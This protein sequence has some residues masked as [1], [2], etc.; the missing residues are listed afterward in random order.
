MDSH[1]DILTLWRFI[2]AIGIATIAVGWWRAY[3]SMQEK[4]RTDLARFFLIQGTMIV[5]HPWQA[6]ML[7]GT[8]IAFGPV[9]FLFGVLLNENYFDMIELHLHEL[10]RRHAQDFFTRERMSYRICCTEQGREYDAWL[11]ECEQTELDAADYFARVGACAS[12]MA[13]YATL[14]L[15]LLMAPFG[16]GVKKASAGERT[17]ARTG[18]IV[19]PREA[20][21]DPGITGVHGALSAG[22]ALVIPKDNA[23]STLAWRLHQMDLKM[24]PRISH[25][26]GATVTLALANFVNGPTDPILVAALDWKPSDRFTLTGGRVLSP[27]GLS[28]QPPPHKLIELARAGTGIT[29]PAFDH[30]ILANWLVASTLELTSGF[31]S[32]H[33]TSGESDLT[34]DFVTT[35]RLRP[36]AGLTLGI[37]AQTGSQPKG[38]RH[39][40]GLNTKLDA[41]SFFGQAE[42]V[43]NWDAGQ[44]RPTIGWYLLGVMRPNPQLEPYVRIER[45]HDLRTAAKSH[46]P[47][48]TLGFNYKPTTNVALRAG[49]TVPLA[50]EP[51]IGLQFAAQV[52]F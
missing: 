47:I 44:Y 13:S 25:N 48:A 50:P 28:R 11:R 22:F 37:E 32:G 21:F 8:A 4:R 27:I 24:L 51:T 12:R 38:W 1:S 31:L 33:G 49:A 23:N 19:D 3:Q 26:V 18:R 29:A 41:G 42:A 6:L 40:L 46:D 2:M 39:M 52:A 7:H 17:S 14:I 45:L 10:R 15:G 36:T 30:G 34:P 5:R 20:P 9:V 35:I 43:A 16:V